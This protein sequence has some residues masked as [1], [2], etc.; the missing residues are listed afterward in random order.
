MEFCSSLS[1]TLFLHPSFGVKSL[2]IVCLEVYDSQQTELEEGGVEMGM[3]QAAAWASK[4]LKHRY[5]FKIL[6]LIRTS[7]WPNKK[8]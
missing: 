5:K 7:N 3:M 8:G 6:L 1:K 4:S 2:G